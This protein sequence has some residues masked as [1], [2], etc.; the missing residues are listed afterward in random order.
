MKSSEEEH[1]YRGHWNLVAESEMPKVVCGSLV[2]PS[3][4][5]SADALHQSLVC[6]GTHMRDKAL[7][8]FAEGF[9]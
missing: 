1:G 9:S 3:W 7:Q 5:E 2:D 4:K 8:F 6:K